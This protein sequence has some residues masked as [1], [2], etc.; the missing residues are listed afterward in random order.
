MMINIQRFAFFFVTLLFCMATLK[1]DELTLEGE[2]ILVPQASNEIDLYG[3]LAIEIAQHDG[4][5]TLIRTFGGQR[6]FKESLSLKTGGF[7]NKVPVTDRV[8]PTNVFMGLSM[9]VGSERT[10]KAFWI[11]KTSHLRLE[12]TCDVLASQGRFSIRC[13]HDFHVDPSPDL[14]TCTITRS[15]REAPIS[16]MLKRKGSREAYY[17]QLEDEWTIGEGLEKQAFL[18]SLQGNANRETARLYFIYPESWNFNYTHHVFDY[19]RD[20]KYY[21]LRQIY[22]LEQAMRTFKE[23]VKGYVVWDTN[24][25]TS[26]IVAFTI[27]GLENAVVVDKSLIPLVK[28]NS[29]EVVEDLRNRFTGWTDAQIYQWAYDRYWNRCSRDFIIWLGGEHGKL[30]K[31]G[32]ADWGMMNRAFFN[33]LSTKPED[34][35]E[36]DLA[37]K[38]LGQMNPMAMVMGWHSYKKDLERDHV[39][40]VS[41]YGLRVEGLHTLP[42]LSFSHHVPA[43]PKFVYRNHHNIEP[44]KSYAPQDK[45]YI[46]CIQTD[47]LGIGAWHKPGRGEIP[48]AWEVIMNYSWLAPAMME[49]FYT[50]ATPNDYFIGALSGPG[51]IYPKAVP[52]NKLPGLIA[53][54]REMMDLLDLRVF[55]IMDYSEGATVEGNTE[56]TEKVVDAYYEGMPDAIGF[57]NGYAPAF[58][59]AVRDKRPLVSYDYYL[60]PTK[61][62]EEAITDL[63]ELAAINARRP[64]FLLMHVREYSNVKRVKSIIDKLGLEFELVPLD[65]FLTMAGEAPTFQERFLKKIIS[66]GFK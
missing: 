23:S 49:Y 62:D 8:F 60:S 15:T 57:V 27:A 20:K 13:Q 55:E 54:A 32:V 6:S 26:L 38:I 42:N 25:R 17:M 45:V 40:L 46:S 37:N 21:T 66:T 48:Y 35:E 61:T 33:D 22:T 19:F 34:K 50:M 31:P 12:E 29:L 10:I 43:T 4:E 16:Y 59:F 28:A 18:I 14:M 36:Y 5:L 7:A 1:A 24:A 11:D 56:L 44:G 65:V 51:Y 63:H 2:W 47:G 53:K 30:M 41:S 3:T 52:K 58:T 64:Y 39:S 9:A